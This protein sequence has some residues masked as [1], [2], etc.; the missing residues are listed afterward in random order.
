MEGTEGRC[1]RAHMRPLGIKQIAGAERTQA[2][3][4]A[5]VLLPC[6]LRRIFPRTIRSSRCWPSRASRSATYGGD[7][8][9]VRGGVCCS[10]VCGKLGWLEE[11]VESAADH[12]ILRRHWQRRT[13]A[14]DL[15]G[16]RRRQRNWIP[17][18]GR[19]VHGISRP[20]PRGDVAQLVEQSRRV[21]VERAAELARMHSVVPDSLKQVDAFSRQSRRWAT[22][23]GQAAKRCTA[24]LAAR[25]AA[26]LAMAL[27][28]EG[29]ESR[30][31]QSAQ[32]QAARGPHHRRAEVGA[33]VGSLWRR[34]RRTA[35]RCSA[36]CTE[37]EWMR[38]MEADAFVARAA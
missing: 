25:L 19:G 38:V 30:T 9:A 35:V 23:Q 16:G 15:G 32:R 20:R 3:D 33:S 29:S 13:T 7:V 37:D 26:A 4:G 21:G 1:R 2:L 28:G 22:A 18:E 31:G 10:E 5:L 11:P 34:Q 8:A 17:E 36:Y 24:R 14:G 27:G 6:V 12:S